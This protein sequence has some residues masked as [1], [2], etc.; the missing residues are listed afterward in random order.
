MTTASSSPGAERFPCPGS[1]VVL[2]GP[3]AEGDGIAIWQV[4]VEGNPTGANAPSLNDARTPELARR[5]LG[6]LERRAVVTMSADAVAQPLRLLTDAAG[7]DD[8]DWWVNQLVD[9]R[10][11]LAEIIEHRG[12]YQ[13]TDSALEW[14]RDLPD[15]DAAPRTLDDFRDLAGIAPVPGEPVVAEALALVRV[16]QWLTRMWTETERAKNRASV[17]ATHGEPLALPPVWQ[18]GMVHAAQTRLPL[19]ASH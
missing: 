8:A 2:L 5:L 9:P 14:Q 6:V 7:I 12:Q 10:E 1:A 13:E 3:K 11:I 17:K 16:L 15:A 18:T 4:S 19:G